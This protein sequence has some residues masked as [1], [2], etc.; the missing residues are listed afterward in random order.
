MK[1]P[2]IRF[3]NNQVVPIKWNILSF[4]QVRWSNLVRYL[5]L[6]TLNCKKKQKTNKQTNKQIKIPRGKNFMKSVKIWKI[7]EG[8]FSKE[9]LYF[10]Y[11]FIVPKSKWTQKLVFIVF[12]ACKQNL[13]ASLIWGKELEV[14]LLMFKSSYICHCMICVPLGI[15]KENWPGF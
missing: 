8:L 9:F 5:V 11:M 3:K 15:F 12:S 6:Y 13:R 2:K 10:K 4:T 1:L 7:H 14:F